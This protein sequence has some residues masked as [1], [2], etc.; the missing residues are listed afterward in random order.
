M[1]VCFFIIII[2][3]HFQA[4][5]QDNQLCSNEICL[6][7]EARSEKLLPQ[8]QKCQK[9]MSKEMNISYNQDNSA[10][11]AAVFLAV[12]MTETYFSEN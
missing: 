9:V 1:G 7:A 8:I 2:A 10:T 6:L 5:K 3:S 11:L 4:Q 12:V